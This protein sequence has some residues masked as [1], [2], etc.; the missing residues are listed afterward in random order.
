M[1]SLGEF[2]NKMMGGYGCLRVSV[3]KGRVGRQNLESWKFH[4][5]SVSIEMA[6]TRAS[7]DTMFREQGV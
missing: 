7:F 3:Q 5:T 1:C 4:H 6:I 2:R